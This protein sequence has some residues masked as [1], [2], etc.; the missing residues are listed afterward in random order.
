MELGDATVAYTSS[1]PE[2]ATVYNG[3]VTGI[4]AGIAKITAAVTTTDGRVVESNPVTVEVLP[5]LESV[6]VS[7]SKSLLGTGFTAQLTV[8]GTMT[9]DEQADLSKANIAYSSNDVQIAFVDPSGIVHP[10]S[11]GSVAIKAAVTLNGI[12]REG[13]IDL[14]VD[15]TKPEY[16]LTVNGTVLKDGGTFEDHLG[17]DFH[18]WDSLSGLGFC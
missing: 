18:A 6:S 12:T 13:S 8:K 14:A 2:V 7:T 10:V 15:A 17:I 9:G 16:E 4:E 3:I 5:I 1:N 11:D